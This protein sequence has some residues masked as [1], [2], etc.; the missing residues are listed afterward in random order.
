ME[1]YLI[2]KLEVLSFSSDSASEISSWMIGFHYLTEEEKESRKKELSQIIANQTTESLTK[3]PKLIAS[4][5]HF[6]ILFT[7]D[8]APIVVPSENIASLIEYE[9]YLCPLLSKTLFFLEK[10]SSEEALESNYKLLDN[11]LLAF[12]DYSIEESSAVP[13]L[14]AKSEVFSAM[15]KGEEPAIADEEEEEYLEDTLE[16]K[17]LNLT[18]SPNLSQ[19]S[20]WELFFIKDKKFPLFMENLQ[21]MDM[22]RTF[23]NMSSEFSF[24]ETLIIKCWELYRK[25]QDFLA[26]LQNTAL[27]Q[28]KLR[29]LHEKQTQA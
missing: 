15:L 22:Q 11:N 18:A 25:K 17:K 7:K 9:E 1:V 21:A 3:L 24:P 6:L 28:S 19:E 29:S 12:L 20:P 16:E 10:R 26:F 27:C 14:I 5:I 8:K 4:F 13:E 2:P 23:F